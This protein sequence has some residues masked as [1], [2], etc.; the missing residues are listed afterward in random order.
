[1]KII[2]GYIAKGLF[3]PG[4]DIHWI[5]EDLA[6]AQGESRKYFSR[7]RYRQVLVPC[8]LNQREEGLYIVFDA[9]Q[10]S[11]TPGQFAAW[12]DADELIGSGVID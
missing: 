11:I 12:Y 8:T 6:L 7:V 10:K 4:N 9:P 2:R 3:I 5:R 1:V